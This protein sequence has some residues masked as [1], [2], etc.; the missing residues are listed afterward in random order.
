ML[1]SEVADECFVFQSFAGA[2][3]PC[4]A[5]ASALVY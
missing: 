2:E 1:R 4:F 5:S 3:I